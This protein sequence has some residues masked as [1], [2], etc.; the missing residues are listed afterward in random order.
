MKKIISNLIIFGCILLVIFGI[1]FF[2]YFVYYYNL[3]IIKGLLGL[4]ITFLFF[5]IFI[6]LPTTINS[7]RIKLVNENFILDIYNKN[8]DVEHIRITDKNLLFKYKCE[9]RFAGILPKFFIHLMITKKELYKTPTFIIK[10][11]NQLTAN[12]VN[13]IIEEINDLNNI[14]DGDIIINYKGN[15]KFSN[16]NDIDKIFEKYFLKN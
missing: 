4:F 9:I 11:K 3:N 1:G 15:K 2:I 7:N 6:I 12:E 8:N 13:N 14:V 16:K 10:N 5:F